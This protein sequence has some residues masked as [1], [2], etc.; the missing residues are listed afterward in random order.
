MSGGPGYRLTE[1]ADEDIVGILGHS[2]RMIGLIQRNAYAALIDKAA[3]MVAEAPERPGARDRDDL[4]DVIRSFHVERAA[5]R[6]GAAAHVLFYMRGTLDDGRD[7]VIIL[8]VLHEA[9]EPA[10]HLAAGLE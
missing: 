9:M 1:I 8:R 3:N 2:A 5:G 4:G 6:R 7:G 10:L